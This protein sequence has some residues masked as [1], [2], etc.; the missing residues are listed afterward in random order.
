MHLEIFIEMMTHTELWNNQLQ[1]QNTFGTKELYRTEIKCDLGRRNYQDI[2][3][4]DQIIKA[5]LWLLRICMLKNSK[6]TNN[7]L[8]TISIQYGK[9]C[10]LCPYYLF[11][12]WASW[13]WFIIADFICLCIWNWKSD[14]KA[15]INGKMAWKHSNI[16]KI[17]HFLNQYSSFTL[18]FVLS[19]WRGNN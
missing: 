6:G 14:H 5:S 2:N 11:L 17:M 4:N 15:E 18:N 19:H 12:P 7:K 3:I 9:K 16:N 8:I 13:P 1:Y 10:N